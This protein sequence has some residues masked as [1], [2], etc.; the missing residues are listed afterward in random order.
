MKIAQE[1]IR[2]LYAIRDA[3][4]GDS[5]EDGNKQNTDNG[6]MGADAILV[7]FFHSDT[8]KTEYVIY[9]NINDVINDLIYGRKIDQNAYGTNVDFLYKNKIEDADLVGKA[10]YGIIHLSTY[11]GIN[12]ES[13]QEAITDLRIEFINSNTAE[14][15]TCVMDDWYNTDYYLIYP[16]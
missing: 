12:Q 8:Q 15:Y 9:D 3:L 6:L 1:L 13:T 14:N 10:R 5:K 7:H 16:K 11:M 2:A 4:L